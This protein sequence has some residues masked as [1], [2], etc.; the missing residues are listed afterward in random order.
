MQSSEDLTMFLDQH[1][2]SPQDQELFHQG[3]EPHLLPA[4]VIQHQHSPVLNIHHHQ[5]L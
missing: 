5:L 2:D 1:K 3:I 4:K